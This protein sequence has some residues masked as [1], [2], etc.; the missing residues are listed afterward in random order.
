[1]RTHT[2]LAAQQQVVAPTTVAQ[3]QAPVAPMQL[4]AAPKASATQLRAKRIAAVQQAL[5]A[6]RLAGKQQAFALAT[7]KSNNARYLVAAQN[8]AAEY[9]LPAPTLAVRNTNITG[10]QQRFAPSAKSGACKQVHALC[11]ANPTAG[12]KA[13]IALCRSSRY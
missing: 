5:Y 1:M 4:L 8:L 10:G 11:A 9:G 12:R 7:T 6:K 2:K 3:T 13:T